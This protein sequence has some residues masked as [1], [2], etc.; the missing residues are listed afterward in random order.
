MTW[1]T[2]GECAESVLIFLLLLL[3]LLSS[4]SLSGMLLLL[5]R[6]LMLLL[7][8]FPFNW[9][10]VPRLL[11]LNHSLFLPFQPRQVHPLVFF[12]LLFS[13]L[14][15]LFFFHS[16]LLL[17]WILLVQLC[18]VIQL[19]WGFRVLYFSPTRLFCPPVPPTSFSFFFFVVFFFV[20]FTSSSFF[21]SPSSSSL[22]EKFNDRFFPAES[23]STFFKSSFLADALFSWP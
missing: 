18:H 5:W 12:R 17:I 10:G 7:L 14:G 23:P 15:I 13:R 11:F 6:W 8:R 1:Q 21:I 16:G 22:L 2:V 4:L 9:C 3:L 19:L 20:F